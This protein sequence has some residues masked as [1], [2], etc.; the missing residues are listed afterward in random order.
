MAENLN[1]TKYR[2]GDLIGT[3]TPDTLDITNQSEPK[4]QWPCTGNE[5]SVAVYGRLYTWYALTDPRNVCPNGWH[6]PSDAEWTTMEEYLIANG[7]NYD[8]TSSGDKT[9]KAMAAAHNWIPTTEVGSVGNPDFPSY[10]NKSG[11]SALPGG[12]R[13][14]EG[15]FLN[16]GISNDWWCSTDS[17]ATHAWFRNVY[18]SYVDVYRDIY[19]KNTAFSVRCIK[20]E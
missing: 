12:Y 14:T 17:T 7:Y 5:D 13:T 20:D 15:A 4:Y 2:N 3:T 10:R 1:V 18:N 8:G 6:L 16:I 9:A 11:F 19:S